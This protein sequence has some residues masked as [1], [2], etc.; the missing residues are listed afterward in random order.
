MNSRIYPEGLLDKAINDYLK[1][2]YCPF[3]YNFLI[4]S[5]IQHTATY[6]SSRDNSSDIWCKDCKIKFDR[7]NL[8]TKEE[9]RNEKID[10]VLKK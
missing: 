5:V 2:N 8:L 6:V 1:K 10:E 4:G 7:S 3:C 9:I